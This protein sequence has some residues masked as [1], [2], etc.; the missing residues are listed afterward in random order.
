MKQFIFKNNQFVEKSLANIS[1]D[2]RG[3]LFG[4]GIFETCKIFNGRIYDFESHL[5]R[6]RRA[7]KAFRFTAELSDLEKKS[8]ELIKKNQIQNGILRIS[9]SRGIG[10]AGYLPTYQ[11]KPLIIIKT[12]DEASFS[13]N[14]PRKI[15]LGISSYK[16]P[17]SNSFPSEFKSSQSFPYV[18]TKIESQEKDLFDSVILS[19]ENFICETSSAN[20][21]WIKKGKI[22]TPSKAC[23]MVLGTIRKKL[24]K[25]SSI[26][27]HEVEKTVSALK[28]ADEIF[29]T[30]ASFLVLSVDEFLGRKLQKDSGKMFLEL[31]QNDVEERCKR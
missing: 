29:L 5:A 19:Q 24:L 8:S 3:F 27:I 16:K 2:E 30:N 14:F 20:I 4:D 25:I 15:S 13:E 17:P 6:I 12:I 22:F 1:I 23:E 7:L 26:K 18:L 11:S 10:S 31:L 21:F 9:I 28:N